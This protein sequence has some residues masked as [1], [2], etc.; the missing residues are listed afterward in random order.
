MENLHLSTTGFI[1]AATREH[2]S[3]FTYTDPPQQRQHCKNKKHKIKTRRRGGCLLDSSGEQDTLEH[4][5][6]EVITAALIVFTC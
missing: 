4:C 3:L 1:P 5:G 6:D 2:E